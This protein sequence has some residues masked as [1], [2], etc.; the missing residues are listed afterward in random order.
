[1]PTFY[2]FDG[3]NFYP[4]LIGDYLL[5]RCRVTAP[6]MYGPEGFDV[7]FRRVNRPPLADYRPTPPPILP[8]AS[9]VDLSPKDITDA[10]AQG[11]ADYLNRKRTAA[12]RCSHGIDPRGAC[13]RCNSPERCAHAVPRGFWCDACRVF[14]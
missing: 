6:T 10:I 7:E 11:A 9:R 12:G 2:H 5:T 4:V 3:E 14:V 13:S 8:P 1:M